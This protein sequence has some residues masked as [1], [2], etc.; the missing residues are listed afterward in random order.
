MDKYNIHLASLSFGFEVPFYKYNDWSLNGQLGAGQ[1][2]L[3]FASEAGAFDG[4]LK[5][6]FW[7]MQLNIRTNELWREN[8]RGQ[9]AYNRKSDL[10]NSTLDMV[11]DELRLG[12]EFGWQ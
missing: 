5:E 7:L 3:T 12:I 6:S 1:G 9:L 11:E 8:L 10:G 4:N 2:L